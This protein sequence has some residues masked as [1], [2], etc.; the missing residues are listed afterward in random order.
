LYDKVFD[1]QAK[2]A[3]RPRQ[4][5]KAPE[6]DHPGKRGRRKWKNDLYFS[7]YLPFSG[8]YPLV[9]IRVTV[10]RLVVAVSSF[11]PADVVVNFCL[12]ALC[13]G[14]LFCAIAVQVSASLEWD[15]R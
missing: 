1:E 3:H 14:Q 11:L 8:L 10:H 15:K 6:T 4:A 5:K 7:L 2:I 9:A 12:L 13:L